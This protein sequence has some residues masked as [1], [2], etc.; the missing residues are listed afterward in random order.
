MAFSPDGTTL[1]TGGYDG[2]IRLWNPTTHK[3]LGR[4]TGHTG[5]VTDVVFSPDGRTLAT[6]GEDGTVRLW[7]EVLWRTVAELKATV[8]DIILAGLT[9]SEWARYASGIS[10][11]RSCP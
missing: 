7:S 10:Y 8:C 6:G 2:T 11:R 1:A 5:A 3:Q 9:P 4:L